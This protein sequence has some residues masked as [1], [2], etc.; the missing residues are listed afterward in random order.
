[1]AANLASLGRDG[2]R[3]YNVGTGIEST[4]VEIF[5]L[6][7]DTLGS[8]I[9]AVHGPPKPGEQRR[10]SIDPGRLRA[11]LGAGSPVELRE[12]L[13]RTLAWFRERRSG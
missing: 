9:E 3:I 2:F 10:S 12:G 8:S 13:A 6:L 1:M 4:V 5:E 11:E 7:R